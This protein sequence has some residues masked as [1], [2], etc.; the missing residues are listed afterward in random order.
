ML[1]GYILVIDI[2]DLNPNNTEEQFR[3]EVV[4][5]LN[6]LDA[7]KGSFDRSPCTKNFYQYT[8]ENEVYEDGCWSVRA[9]VLISL[10]KERAKYLLE[11]YKSV[12][13]LIMRSLPANFEVKCSAEQIRFS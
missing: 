9:M 8:S 12:S 11:L 7:L 4:F 1:P 5:V 2:V 6:C 3:E 13:E 10:G